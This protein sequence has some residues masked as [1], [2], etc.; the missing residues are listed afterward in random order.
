M[1]NCDEALNTL[2]YGIGGGVWANLSEHEEV[3][4]VSLAISLVFLGL[5]EMRVKLT[6]G[7]EKSFVY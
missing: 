5:F 7:F 2:L 1:N 4:S 6:S 3:G